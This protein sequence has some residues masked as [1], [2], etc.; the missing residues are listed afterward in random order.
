MTDEQTTPDITIN[1]E[2]DGLWHI[3]LAQPFH[4]ERHYATPSALDA[5]GLVDCILG[6]LEPETGAA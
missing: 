1:R 2:A 5:L 6:A 3:T 4:G